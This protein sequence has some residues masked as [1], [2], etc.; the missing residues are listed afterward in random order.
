MEGPSCVYLEKEDTLLL[1]K[2]E[3][4]EAEVSIPGNT[5]KIVLRRTSEGLRL[6]LSTIRGEASVKKLVI[7][8]TG[9]GVLSVNEDLPGRIKGFRLSW[10]G[11]SLKIIGLSLSEKPVDLKLILVPVDLSRF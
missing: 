6:S 9:P 11:R 7:E 5:L 10:D 8:N 4:G 1:E 3:P 2:L